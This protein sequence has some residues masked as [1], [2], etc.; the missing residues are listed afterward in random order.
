MNVKLYMKSGN[1]IIIKEVEDFKITC[2]GNTIKSINV[3]WE[4]SKGSRGVMIGS[5][6][7]SQI[8]AIESF[9]G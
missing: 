5:L 2:N 8:E 9:D 4:D 7:L 6:D 3:E 1:Q